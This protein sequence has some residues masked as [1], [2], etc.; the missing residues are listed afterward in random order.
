MFKVALIPVF[1]TIAVSSSDTFWV[2]K[3]FEEFYTQPL[4][5]KRYPN[6]THSYPMQFDLD[7]THWTMHYPP[8]L[9]TNVDLPN[10]PI[11]GAKGLRAR[12]S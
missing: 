12:L 4:D 11:K 3:D 5:L 8:Y 10:H 1:I 7:S 6:H 9:E 2:E